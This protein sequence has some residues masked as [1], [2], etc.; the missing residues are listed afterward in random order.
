MRTEELPIVYLVASGAI[1]GTC[2][3]V[4]TNPME[5]VKINMQVSGGEKTALDVARGLGI[6]GMYKFMGATL[7][8]YADYTKILI[9]KAYFFLVKRDVPFSM[10]Y[11]SL[12]GYLKQKI[13]NQDGYVS[14]WKVL[15]VSTFSGIFSAAIATPPD[16]IKTRLQVSPPKGVEPYKGIVDCVSRTLKAEGPGAFFKGVVPRVLVVSPLFGIALAVYELQK[17]L[18]KKFKEKKEQI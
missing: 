5:V 7:L 4:A 16:V 15:G 1:A 18:I 12:Y 3:V 14:P 17:T 6:R 2:Q 10:A 11:F 13:V 8:R 9:C